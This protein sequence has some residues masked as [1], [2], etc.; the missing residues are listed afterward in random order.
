MV[1]THIR[2]DL[3]GSVAEISRFVATTK[4]TNDTKTGFVVRWPS[5]CFRAF[6]QFRGFL[7]KPAMMLVLL[8]QRSS[9]CCG[10]EAPGEMDFA[11]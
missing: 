5:F 8:S 7:I 1:A 2:E 9:I 4:D 10:C 11:K 3:C 6:R